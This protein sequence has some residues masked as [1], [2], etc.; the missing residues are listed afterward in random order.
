M[1]SINPD[2]HSIAE[3]DLVKWGVAIARKGGV[4]K[5]KVVNAMGLREMTGYLQQRK[6][7]WA[8]RPKA[9]HGTRVGRSGREG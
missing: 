6:N 3:L 1:L 2:A 7:R 9:C 8:A 4:P 5:D